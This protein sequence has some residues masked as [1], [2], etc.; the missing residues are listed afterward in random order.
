MANYTNIKDILKQFEL[1]VVQKKHYKKEEVYTKAQANTAISNAV[2]TA[3]AGVNQFNIIVSSNAATTPK[4]V[5]WTSDSTT[6][7]GTLEA[8]SADAHTVYYVKS[9]NGTNDSYDEYMAVSGVWEKI[10]NTDVDL[11][12]YS[13][14]GETVSSIHFDTTDGLY[15][16][17]ANENVVTDKH[18]LGTASNWR[19]FLGATDTVS[20]S[21]AG[22][23]TPKM[24]Y[25]LQEKTI[26]S[27]S[28]GI[29]L[30]GKVNAPTISV[31]TSSKVVAGGSSVVVGAEIYSFVTGYAQPKDADLTAIA[32]LTGTSGFLKK[33]AADTWS[34][35]TNSYLTTTYAENTY[36]KQAYAVATFITNSK[37]DDKYLSKDTASST[38]LS[39][40]DA[41][42][43][44]LTKSD[45]TSTYATNATA[46][47]DVDFNSSKG[48][49][50]KTLDKLGSVADSDYNVIATVA[51]LKS[52]LGIN[53][54]ANKTAAI[55]ASNS[56]IA[57]GGTIAS[58]T[59]TVTGGSVAMANGNVVKG[60]TIYDYISSSSGVLY[61]SDEDFTAILNAV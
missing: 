18:S 20:N 3:I 15:Y 27:S 9:S 21:S 31:D 11:T 54:K 29:T 8:T 37:A 10:G 34:L 28:N 13:T 1:Q 35:D 58:P 24:V 60:G 41:S 19:T 5:K 38:Y 25:N 17:Y 59:I 56:G 49:R 42:S 61:M 46:V 4:G 48:L 43:T 2:N 32:A 26:N 36:V 51:D 12:N 39:K 6:I 55:S 33:T 30:G 50:Y 45:A 44:Y 22:L 23:A 14:L 7:T 53:D 40:T 16:H 57:L 52:G 47:G